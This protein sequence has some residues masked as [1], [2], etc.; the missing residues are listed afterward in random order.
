MRSMKTHQGPEE[1]EVVDWFVV[2][3]EIR[4]S[5]LLRSEREFCV[6]QQSHTH[7]HERGER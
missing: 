1:L 3:D 5:Y 7:R 2:V 4:F 6:R